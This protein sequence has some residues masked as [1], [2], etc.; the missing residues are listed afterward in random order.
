VIGVTVGPLETELEPP[1][2]GLPPEEAGVVAVFVVDV[3]PPCPVGVVVPAHGG[4][5]HLQVPLSQRGA[6]E[7][8]ALPQPPQLVALY[9]ISV[10]VL[11]QYP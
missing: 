1:L 2:A 11:P 10:Q 9:L 6:E 4:V 5:S 3:E 7:G 8:H